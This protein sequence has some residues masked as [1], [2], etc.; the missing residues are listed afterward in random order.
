VGGGFM[1]QWAV[2]THSW[3][4]KGHFFW[5]GGVWSFLCFVEILF[6]LGFSLD[7]VD[8]PLELGLHVGF[9]RFENEQ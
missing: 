7:M 1:R 3:P 8:H 2:H 6:V 5:G 4:H 9:L